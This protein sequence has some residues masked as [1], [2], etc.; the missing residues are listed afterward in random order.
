MFLFESCNILLN[1]MQQRFLKNWQSLSWLKNSP[2]FVEAEYSFPWS[3]EPATGLISEPMKSSPR[4]HD[5]SLIS[6]LA[7]PP[8]TSRCPKWL[9]SALRIFRLKFWNHLSY[10]KCELHASPISSSL[11]LLLFDEVYKLRTPY[12]PISCSLLLLWLFRSEY[13]VQN[14]ALRYPSPV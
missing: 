9:V 10:R 12:Y 13:C 14:P 11:T 5:V 4:S 6:I 3:Q 1:S 2:L 8:S 7:Y